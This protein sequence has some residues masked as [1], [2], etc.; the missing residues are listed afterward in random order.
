V[1]NPQPAQGEDQIVDMLKNQ[2]FPSIDE[3][4]IETFPE[5][6]PLIGPNGQLM[7]KRTRGNQ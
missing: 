6:Q 7:M 5:G 3:I 4:D 2:G 1:Q